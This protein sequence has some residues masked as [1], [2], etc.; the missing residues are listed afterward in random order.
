LWGIAFNKNGGIEDQTAYDMLKGIRV[1][2]NE[3]V[4]LDFVPATGLYYYVQGRNYL[5]GEII[6]DIPEWIIEPDSTKII[7]GYS[8]KKANADYLGRKW[9]VWYSEEIPLNGGP[10]LLWGTPGLILDARD[11]EKM[12][13]FKFT[14]VEPLSDEGR[15]L[16]LK[17]YYPQQGEKTSYY[18]TSLKTAET[19][20]T[21]Y[22]TDSDYFLQEF[23]GI[24][25]G[26]IK[27]PPYTPLIPTEY[28]KTK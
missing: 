7:C 15:R 10:W 3:V 5:A 6:L 8:C 4:L 27:L 23:G 21:K 28:W 17:E 1:G 14:G 20:H 11:S 9:E 22:K 26:K 2:T 25:S 18:Q 13:L 19:L 16:F 24:L 12:F